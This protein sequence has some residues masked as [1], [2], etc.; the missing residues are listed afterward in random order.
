MTPNEAR[1]AML[2]VLAMYERE[3]ALRR[4]GCK[5]RA[6]YET[7]AAALRLLILASPL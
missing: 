1:H 6:K 7:L 4:I 5:G 3:A 2:P